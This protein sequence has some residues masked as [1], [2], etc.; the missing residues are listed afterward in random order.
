MT[1][2]KCHCE[3]SGDVYECQ[4]CSSTCLWGLAQPRL[5]ESSGPQ[6]C[7]GLT[8]W[9]NHQMLSQDM[10][11]QLISVFVSCCPCYTSPW[12][13]SSLYVHVVVTS[14]HRHHEC[15]DFIL[16]GESPG[17]TTTDQAACQCFKNITTV[18]MLIGS[19]RYDILSATYM[20]L[21]CPEDLVLGGKFWRAF[22]KIKFAILAWLF[23]IVVSTNL[24]AAQS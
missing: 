7:T 21:H 9:S 3:L 13:W 11:C 23:N 1:H 14:V 6:Y 19:M 8:R 20:G 10:M 12:L 15:L 16:Y 4:T 5:P 22:K 18:G 2:C 17:G 24:I